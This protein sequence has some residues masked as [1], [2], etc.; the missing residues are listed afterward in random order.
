MRLVSAALVGAALLGAV[1]ASAQTFDLSTVKCSEFLQSGQQNIS[2]IMMWLDGYYADQE[3]PAV[4]NFD[5]M[6]QKGEKLGKYCG[7]NPT[8]GLITAAEE[9]F[10][11]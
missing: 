3:A 6:K 4:I 5:K 9:V 10:Q 8:T 1:P 2:L 7:E 11:N